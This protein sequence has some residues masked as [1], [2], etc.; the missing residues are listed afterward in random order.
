M[1]SCFLALH[2]HTD[3]ETTAFISIGN[4]F[5]NKKEFITVSDDVTYHF[6]ISPYIPTV[7]LRLPYLHITSVYHDT[8]Y[9]GKVNPLFN[10][11]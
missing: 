2:F 8:D 6:K 5:E 1:G 7:D 11:F 4:S 9:T 10:E 3:R